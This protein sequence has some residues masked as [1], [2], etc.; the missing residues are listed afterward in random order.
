MFVPGMY[1]T[2]HRFAPHFGD[3]YSHSKRQIFQLFIISMSEPKKIL[4]KL[5][6]LAL[7][8]RIIYR[9]IGIIV[10]PALKSITQIESTLSIV[11]TGN[12]QYIYR[13]NGRALINHLHS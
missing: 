6:I 7:F 4:T 12:N 1:F 10:I 8:S 9:Y 5:I 11:I 2:K 13:S 3:F